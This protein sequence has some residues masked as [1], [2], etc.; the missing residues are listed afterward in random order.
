MCGIK[1]KSEEPAS[2]EIQKRPRIEDSYHD[3]WCSTCDAHLRGNFDT[4][5]TC[6]ECQAFI[7][8]NCVSDY[9]PLICKLHAGEL[10]G[11]DSDSDDGSDSDSDDGSDSESYSGDGPAL[12]TCIECGFL[13]DHGI[14]C[15]QCDG[16]LC[17]RT[18]CPA[19]KNIRINCCTRCDNI[20]PFSPDSDSEHDES[21]DESDLDIS[22]LPER[23][24][25]HI[26]S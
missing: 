16:F 24:V 22:S 21:A 13:K 15:V 14:L 26:D 18:D 4:L 11:S 9:H 12:L 7:C 17:G 20:S 8:S 5:V 23:V 10:S 25:I 2:L 6:L 3:H 1:R 19:S